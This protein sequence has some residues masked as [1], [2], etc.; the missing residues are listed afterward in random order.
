MAQPLA[1]PEGIG[2]LQPRGCQ[3]PPHL[4]GATAARVGEHR[5]GRW[6]LLQGGGQGFGIAAVQADPAGVLPGAAEAGKGQLQRAGGGVKAQLGRRKALQQQATDAKPKRVATREQHRRP[7]RCQGLLQR[8][9][10]LLGPIAGQELGAG[11]TRRDA[12]GP[13][14]LLP[15]GAKFRQQALR[16]KQQLGSSHQGE[17]AGRQRSHPPGIGADHLQHGLLSQGAPRLLQP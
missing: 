3:D 12:A 8:A 14:L 7:G 1:Q 17:A 4:L 16:G 13:L 5:Q 9:E 11:V 15:P 6:S 2:R 10:N